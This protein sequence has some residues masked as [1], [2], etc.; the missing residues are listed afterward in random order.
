MNDKFIRQLEEIGI[1]LE[2]EKEQMFVKYFDLLID[3]NQKINLTGI[4]AQQ[5]VYEKHFLD[6]LAITQVVD[7][8]K[9]QRIIDVGTGAGFPGIPLKIVFPELK[10]DLLDSLAKRIKFINIVIDE[11]SLDG[12]Q[13]YHGRAEDFAGKEGMRESY[14]LAVSRAVSKLQVLSEYTLPFIKTNGTFIA[15]K[16]GEIEK[17]LEEAKN[18]IQTLGG[19][20]ENTVY[21]KLPMTEI[22]RSFVMVHKIKSTDNKYPRK[23][24]LPEKKPI[25]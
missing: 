19:E 8:N 25:S 17:E 23:A 20:Y 21:L 3:W 2:K 1:K 9:N 7:L 13:A 12:I 14:D 15:Y 18:A 10:I 16:S 22:K 24:G 11:L 6:S 4:T 5:E